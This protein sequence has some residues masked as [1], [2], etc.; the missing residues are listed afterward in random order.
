MR[1][2][3]VPAETEYNH[4]YFPLVLDSERAMH[5]VVEALAAI[6][7]APRRYFY[8]ALSNLPYVTARGS[9]PI[10]ESLALRVICLPLYHD[11]GDADIDRVIAVVRASV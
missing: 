8:P 7:V 5:Q 3:R 1:I 2:A 6:G 10:A 9:C 11:L 4:S